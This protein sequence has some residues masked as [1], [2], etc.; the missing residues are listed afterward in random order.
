MIAI[1]IFGCKSHK[2]S[3]KLEVARAIFILGT[4]VA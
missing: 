1:D 4:G 2:Q 3:Y